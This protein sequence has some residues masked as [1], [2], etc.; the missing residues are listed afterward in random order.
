MICCCKKH[1]LLI[2]CSPF[3]FRWK[4]FNVA[5]LLAPVESSWMSFFASCFATY[6]VNMHPH[7]FVF[8]VSLSFC[9][10]SGNGFINRLCACVVQSNCL[11]PR[12][13]IKGRPTCGLGL[14]IWKRVTCRFVSVGVATSVTLHICMC[15]LYTILFVRTLK[16]RPDGIMIVCARMMEWRSI[17]CSDHFLMP[18]FNTV[19]WE[20]VLLLLGASQSPTINL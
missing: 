11:D 20:L 13:I 5:L 8:L 17:G 14:W 12:S 16:T 7:C 6:C 2:D 10:F 3:G 4:S 15:I 9:Y 19:R 1:F 18:V